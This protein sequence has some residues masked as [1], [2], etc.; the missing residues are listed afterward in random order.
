MKRLALLTA[1]IVLGTAS[2]TACSD[3]DD[4]EK[5]AA[6]RRCPHRP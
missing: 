2:L 5:T 1:A 4:T 3:N 6:R